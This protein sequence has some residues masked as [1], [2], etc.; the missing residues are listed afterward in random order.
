MKLK[1]KKSLNQLK[2][3]LKKGQSIYK[4]NKKD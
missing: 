3:M 4:K 2:Q 1:Q